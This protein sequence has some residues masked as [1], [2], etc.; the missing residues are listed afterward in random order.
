MATLY[1]LTDQDG[2]T[3]A[4]CYNELTWGEG[5]AHTAAVEGVS[6]CT[7]QVIHAYTSPILAV[8]LNPIHAS[9]ENPITWECEGDIVA[10][11]RGLKVGAKTVTCK[12]KME[13][14][15]VT[16]EVRV[17]FAILCTLEV[18]SEPPF[19]KW[20]E[21]W[22][23]G[24]N[25]GA[26]SAAYAASSAAAAHYAADAAFAAHAAFATVA[27]AVSAADCSVA[28]YAA[29]AVDAAAY[30]DEIDLVEIAEKAFRGDAK[31]GLPMG[32]TT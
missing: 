2:K 30:A 32:L 5:V 19:V 31:V 22:L 6:L 4:G 27:A 20:A 7:D 9:I 8:L 16:N 28:H 12:R 26:S 14:I 13:T 25:R 18:Y 23:S 11:G 3:R 29:D 17:R 10:N 21:G 1:K 15:D 24:E